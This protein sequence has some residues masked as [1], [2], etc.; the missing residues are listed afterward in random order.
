MWPIPV[1]E[2]EL[3]VVTFSRNTMTCSWIQKIGN[4]R[5]PLVL[6]AYKRYQLDNNE[7][8]HA[9]L[10][11]PTTIKY[12]IT[13]F[14]YEHNQQNAFVAFGCDGFILD[15]QYTALPT[16]TPHRTDFGVSSR[17][18]IMWDY[19]Y[20]YPND[21]GQFVFYLYTMPRSLILQYQLL[22]IAAQCNL[23]T[24]TTTSMALLSAYQHIFGS[25]FRRSQLAID[26][27]R[28]NNAINTLISADILKRIIQVPAAILLQDELP[29]IAAACG[30]FFE[31]RIGK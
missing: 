22:A 28:H 17:N 16:S 6:R 2:H 7:I 14:L 20:L 1:L 19:R 21:H 5:A 13:S 8:V 24:I 30:I 3:C 29:Y 31:E 15:E 12:N 11:N 18:S 9:N 10:F 4:G 27:A 23:I 25:A 26:M